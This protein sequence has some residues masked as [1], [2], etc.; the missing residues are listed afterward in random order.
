MLD[1][2]LHVLA[3]FTS[4]AASFSDN[5]LLLL[6]FVSLSYVSIRS[7]LMV[8]INWICGYS[9]HQY[10]LGLGYHTCAAWLLRCVHGGD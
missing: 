6:H 2:I 8:K 4:L 3:F 1:F 10:R 7:L 9:P 5:R